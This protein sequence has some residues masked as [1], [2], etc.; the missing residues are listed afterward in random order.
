M[1]I[2]H[3]ADWHLGKMFYGEYLTEEQAYVLTEQFL[4]MLKEENV[5]AV[6]LAGDVLS[7]IHI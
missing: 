5:D 4:P 7:L 3:S 6:V 1:R 2:L